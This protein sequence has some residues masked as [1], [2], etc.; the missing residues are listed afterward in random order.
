MNNNKLYRYVDN[1]V[2][3]IKLHNSNY[4]LAEQI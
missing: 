2:Y 4:A 3:A 1:N